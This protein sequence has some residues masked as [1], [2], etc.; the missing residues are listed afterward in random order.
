MQKLG[1]IALGLSRDIYVRI[2][3]IQE[4]Q[5]KFID[6]FQIISKHEI[7]KIPIYANIMDVK[8]FETLDAESREVNKKGIL[9]P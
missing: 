6:E 3:A 8:D 5:G 7:Y 9:K 1:P 4:I 2:N